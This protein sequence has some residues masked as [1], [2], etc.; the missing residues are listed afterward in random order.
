MIINCRRLD[1]RHNKKSNS[2][3]ISQ[4]TI[5]VS[6][7]STSGPSSTTNKIRYIRLNNHKQTE[8]YD[9]KLEMMNKRKKKN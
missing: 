8:L 6:P 4:I 7:Y 9:S 5:R 1:R 3:L 2:R